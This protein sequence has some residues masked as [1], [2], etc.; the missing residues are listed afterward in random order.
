MQAVSSQ[1]QAVRDFLNVKQHKEN[2]MK[3]TQGAFPYA[4]INNIL[5]Q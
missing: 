2:A 3:S 5:K 4:A 1:E